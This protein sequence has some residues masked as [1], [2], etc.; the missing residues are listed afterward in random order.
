M[1]NAS[2]LALVVQ[3]AAR[4]DPAGAIGLAA[5]CMIAAQLAM[6]ATAALAATRADVW[7]RRPFFLAAFAALA[8]RA[9]LYTLS[10]NPA[11]TIFVQLLDGVGVG[12]FGALFP[13]VIADLTRGSGHFNIAQ[14]SVGTVHSIG[15]IMSGLIANAVVVWV[16]YEAAFLTLAAIATLG[17]AL[18]WLVMPE[19][20]ERGPSEL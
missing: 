16:S 2:M 14:G 20:H 19:T 11:W 15:G 13:V 9:V 3:R 7:G 18:F 1:A 5:A 10:D 8:L 17:T 12:V 4:T 6:V